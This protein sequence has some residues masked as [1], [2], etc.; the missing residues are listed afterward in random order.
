[1]AF[2]D[3]TIKDFTTTLAS[4]APVP[5]GGSVAAVLGALG[6]SLFAMVAEITMAKKK[7]EDKTPIEEAL[8]TL[9]PLGGRF[10][11]LIDEDAAAF[12]KVMAAF[13]MPKDDEEKQSAR[14]AAIEEA[15]IGAA[16]VPGETADAALAALEAGRALAELGAKS[17]ISDIACGALCLEAAARGAAYNIQINL[18]GLEGADARS[19][20]EEA[21]AGIERRLGELAS[22]RTQAESRIS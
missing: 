10:L 13:K 2:R 11:E 21:L 15:V 8:A 5:G 7:P 1:M 22:V 9:A 19:R 6:A 16:E 20:F 17:A 14:K 18:A 4:S 12:E 3:D